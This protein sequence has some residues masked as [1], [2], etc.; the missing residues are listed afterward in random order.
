[1]FL[2]DKHI[3]HASNVTVENGA[4]KGGFN[5]DPI[6]TIN[7]NGK[8]LVE[9]V[10]YTLDYT[11]ITQ[12]R[13]EVTNGKTLRVKLAGKGGY[14]LA[15]DVKTKQFAWGIDA[16]DLADAE[17]IVTGTDAEP[18]VK[19]M[20]GSV[21]V[22]KDNYD[23][24]A[25]N[26]KVTVT[27]TKG[28]KNYVGSKTADIKEALAKPAQAMISDV[29]VVGN[30]ATVVLSGEVEGAVGY[31]YVI[32]PNKNCINDKDYTKVLRNKLTT[33]TTFQYVDQG[34]YYAYCH[35]WTRD[36]NGKKVFGEWSNAYPFSVTS[37]TPSQ[38]VVTS[39][40]VKGSTV[41]VKYT[42]SVNAEGYDVVLG[43]KT[44]L[45]A[46]EKRPVEYGKLVKKNI[47]GN[48][49]TATFKNVKKGTYYAGLHSFNRTSEDG[50]KVFSP[51]SNVKRVVVK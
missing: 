48:T 50:K 5:V 29:K 12:N 43:S 30:K 17:L 37:I 3:I 22:S 45:V 14:Y 10:D 25:E 28:N 44:A 8:K 13:T 4:Y 9:G 18:V 41:T 35:A 32:S 26:G 6:V 16:F 38:P 27:A 23:V 47:N 11:G 7:Y 20:N 42:A 19:V 15:D 49:V 40:T 36:E 34:M 39:V 24:T 31:D 33:D 21:V 2:I 1:M 51:W 46:G